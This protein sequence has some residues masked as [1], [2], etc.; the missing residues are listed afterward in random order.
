MQKERGVTNKAR[1][2]NKK[3]SVGTFQAFYN[4]NGNIRT[5]ITPVNDKGQL[6]AYAARAATVSLP[7][8]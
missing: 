4:G 8:M 1:S 3:C 7:A 6:T 2:K 5:G